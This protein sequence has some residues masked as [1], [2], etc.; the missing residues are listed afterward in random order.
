MNDV[1]PFYYSEN[2][3]R[4]ITDSQ[5]EP[6]FVAKDVCDVLG[7]DNITWAL[8]G[9][10]EDELTLEKLNSG[11]QTREMKLIS[12]SGLYT[13][14]IRSNKPQAKAFRRWVTHEVLPAIR[15]TGGYS[16]AGF[17]SS[18][19]ERNQA[20]KRILLAHKVI[21][22]ELRV[23]KRIGVDV[24][25]ARKLAVE[26]AREATGIDY[27]PLLP[28]APRQCH[29][30]LAECCELDPFF[31]VPTLE[32]YRSYRDWAAERPSSLSERMFVEN[33]LAVPGIRKER[34]R[35]QGSRISIFRGV[36]MKK[37]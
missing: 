5:G 22:N 4:I 13:L 34:P 32:L 28:A 30:F 21:E 7:L 11:G 9:L 29:D 25:T 20:A 12:E 2:E 8:N 35:V 17:N 15:K 1:V 10:D 36:R 24:L 3:I 18:C 19:K 33:L 14:I 27:A 6:W 16:A 23:C 37:T 31:F 26:N